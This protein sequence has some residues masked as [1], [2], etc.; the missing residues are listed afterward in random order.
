MSGARAK[1]LRRRI[2]HYDGDTP[3]ETM[4]IFIY[5]HDLRPRFVRHLRGRPDLQREGWRDLVALTG[6]DRYHPKGRP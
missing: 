4:F 1:A 3:P 2:A 6:G 5:V